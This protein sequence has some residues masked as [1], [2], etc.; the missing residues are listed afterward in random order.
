MRQLRNFRAGGFI[1]PME[2]GA[3]SIGAGEVNTIQEQH[4]KMNIQVQGTA[5]TLYKRDRACVSGLPGVT[6][7]MDQVRCNGTVNDTQHPAHDGRMAG[8]QKA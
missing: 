7:L 2:T 6:G 5:E 3:C 4:V 8:K 1:D